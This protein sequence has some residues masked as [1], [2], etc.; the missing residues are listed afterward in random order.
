MVTGGGA[1]RRGL[2]GRDYGL[3]DAELSGIGVP[4]KTKVHVLAL[5]LGKLKQ[6]PANLVPGVPERQQGLVVL[7]VNARCALGHEACKL[8]QRKEED[9]IG[10]LRHVGIWL[11]DG[12]WA[13][14][15][16]AY[17]PVG[18]H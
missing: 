13:A 7:V 4:D 10:R 6:L 9:L 16:E 15:A 12:G 1:A 17:P 14:E 11:G 5:L 8:D 3:A 18:A 2:T